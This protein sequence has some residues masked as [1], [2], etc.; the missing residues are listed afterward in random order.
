M[1]NYKEQFG[2]VG[3][4]FKLDK[5]S[6]PFVKKLNI[7]SMGSIEKL[8]LIEAFDSTEKKVRAI[9]SDEEEKDDNQYGFYHYKGSLTT[10]PCSDI[11]NWFVYRKVLPIS[12]SDLEQLRQQWH[13]KLGHHNYRECQPL[14]GRRV[15]KNFV[16]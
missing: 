16:L 3:I 13:C 2:V 14:Y 9:D 8:N 15:V 4:L 7:Q 10:P 11:V 5:E 6:H 1:D 12:E